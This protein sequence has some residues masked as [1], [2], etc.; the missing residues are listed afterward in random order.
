MHC[1]VWSCFL[2]GL[3]QLP[4]LWLI[5]DKLKYQCDLDGEF[6]EHSVVITYF[7]GSPYRDKPQVLFHG[8]K[9]FHVLLLFPI[10]PQVKTNHPLPLGFQLSPGYVRMI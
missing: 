7:C 4:S 3:L 6:H 8:Q 1:N 9:S 5:R 2:S 10:A